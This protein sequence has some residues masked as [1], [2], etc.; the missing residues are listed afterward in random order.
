M[1]PARPESRTAS[2]REIRSSPNMLD[3]A[4]TS[5][6]DACVW[7]SR[8]GLSISTVARSTPKVPD[9]RVSAASM[10]MR[11]SIPSLRRTASSRLSATNGWT[12]KVTFGSRGLPSSRAVVR[13]CV[14]KAFMRF[15]SG[16]IEKMTSA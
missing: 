13:I 14:M 12:A 4:L 5:P 6:R 2:R 7:M 9:M 3:I 10:G 8:S 15:R 11:A 1:S 16:W